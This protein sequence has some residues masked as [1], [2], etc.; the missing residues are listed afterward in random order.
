MLKWHLL[1]WY[2]LSPIIEYASKSSSCQ[3]VLFPILICLNP[4]LLLPFSLPEN[5][6]THTHTHSLSLS[7]NKSAYKVTGSS[8]SY[9]KKLK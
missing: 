9:F 6:H 1:G 4:V 8:K 3:H 5:D 2:I 7:T